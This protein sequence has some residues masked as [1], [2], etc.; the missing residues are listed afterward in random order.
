[1]KAVVVYDTYYGNTKRVAEAVAD[2]LKA[3]GHEVDLRSVR[4]DYPAPPMGDL[5]FVGSPIRFGGPTGRIKKFVKKLDRTAWKDKPCVV[6][7]TT[8]PMPKESEPD[9]KKQSFDKWGLGGG[10]KLRDLAKSRGLNAL[11]NFLWV[12]VEQPDTKTTKIVEGG[13]EKT[14]QFTREALLN[15]KK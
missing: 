8:M 13:I 10:R 5:M 11:D 3:E 15:L 1:L 9:K 7:T 12:E 6:F 4:D 14:K 2:E